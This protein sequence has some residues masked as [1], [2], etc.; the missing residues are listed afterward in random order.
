MRD[1]NTDQAT[2]QS[3]GGN[4]CTA[5]ES[6]NISVRRL[7]HSGTIRHLPYLPGGTQSPASVLPAV[8]VAVSREHSVHV[9]EPVTLAKKLI[10]HRLQGRWPLGENCPTGHA[11]KIKI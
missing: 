6:D 11:S 8:G 7:K 5:T 3:S 1:P 4:T 9:V 2:Y 10:G